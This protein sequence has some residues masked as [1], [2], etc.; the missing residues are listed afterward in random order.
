VDG[1]W[2]AL[3][4]AAA[5]VIAPLAVIAAALELLTHRRRREERA[6]T[7]MLAVL[8]SRETRGMVGVQARS[9]VLSRTTAVTL[10]TAYCGSST[11]W[12]VLARAVE[13]APPHVEVTV[14]CPHISGRAVTVP[15]PHTGPVRV[16]R[17]GAGQDAAMLHN[18]SPA[19]PARPAPPAAAAN[20]AASRSGSL[21]D[22]MRIAVDRN[23]LS[24]ARD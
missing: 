16:P 19:R 20:P 9:G 15:P 21:P 6:R 2:L 18:G 23:A 14:E 3:V 11:V 5:A 8:E 10:S 17:A 1:G 22:P 13:Q 7:A 12:T 24:N 4:S